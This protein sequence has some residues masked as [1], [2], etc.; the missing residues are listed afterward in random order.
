[1]W[2]A[3]DVLPELAERVAAILNKEPQ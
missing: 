3:Q 1:P 2:F